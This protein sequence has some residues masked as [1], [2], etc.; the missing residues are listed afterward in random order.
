MPGVCGTHYLSIVDID[1]GVLHE[2]PRVKV[3]IY[4]AAGLYKR[5]LL[6]NLICSDYTDLGDVF[7]TVL[8]AV[9]GRQGVVSPLFDGKG[10]TKEKFFLFTT[11]VLLP[12]IKDTGEEL[13]HLIIYQV[14]CAR[15]YCLLLYIS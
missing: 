4:R 11:L 10:T 9:D 6:P 12:A 14:L 8:I 5:S 13:L 2:S 1:E 7:Y 3:R 15:R